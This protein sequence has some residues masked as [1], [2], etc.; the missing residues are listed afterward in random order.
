MLECSWSIKNDDESRPQLKI[1]TLKITYDTCH[2]WEISHVFLF[3]LFSNRK[4]FNFKDP[5]VSL[6]MIYRKMFSVF[7]G[8]CFAENKWSTENIFMVNW[9]SSNFSVKCLTDLKNVKH[10][11]SFFFSFFFSRKS[12]SRK[13]FSESDFPWNNRSLNVTVHF[14]TKVP[15]SQPIN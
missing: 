13:H 6:K 8:V 1:H 10:F 3:F 12:F 15:L 9:K 7:L 4:V 5:F 14:I 11:T 2:V